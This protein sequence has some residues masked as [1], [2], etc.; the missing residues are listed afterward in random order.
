MKK[1]E[2]TGHLWPLPPGVK[3]PLELSGEVYLVHDVDERI[4][5]LE[6]LLR[7]V[8]EWRPALPAEATL[9]DEIDEALR[10]SDSGEESL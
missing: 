1:Y 4:G 9:I 3:L 8:V 7:R 6:S 2:F 10:A 5:K